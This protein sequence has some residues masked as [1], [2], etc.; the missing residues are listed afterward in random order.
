MFMDIIIELLKSL[1]RLLMN[2]LLYIAILFTILLGYRRVINERKSF[3]IRIHWG[4]SEALMLLKEGRL[5]IVILS[6][7]S[8]GLGFVLP[9]EYIVL[10]TALSILVIVLFYYHAASVA[11]PFGV[12]FLILWV[13]YTNDTSF[14]FLKWTFDASTIHLKMLASIPILIGILLIAEGQLV[15]RY[16]ARLASPRLENTSRGLK[17]VTFL[18][19]RLWVLPVFFLIPGD[20]ISGFAPYWPVFSIGGESYGLIIFPV[21]L[22]FQQRA[23]KMLPVHFY[24][25]IGRTITLLGI[26][27]AVEGIIAYFFPIIGIAAVIVAI[28]GRILISVMYSINERKGKYA[29]T[30]HNEGVV[31]AAVLPNSP[32]EAMDLQVG[33]IIR[34]VNGLEVHTEDELYHALQLNAAHCKIEVI[35]IEGEMR[36][37]QHV[38]FHHDHFRI[39]LLLVK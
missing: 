2:P 25:Q 5:W 21:V 32:A 14:S 38:I 29:V 12:A 4:L 35:D 1:G 10:V 39:G 22:G 13:I 8:L 15:K 3:R 16:A 7:I 30:P 37:R 11:Y 17:A 9:M 20:T 27:V 23:R 6:V 36:L 18:A 26:L 31:I 28:I 34:K 33:E 24:P 19:K